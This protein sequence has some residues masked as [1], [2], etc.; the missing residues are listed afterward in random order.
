[1]LDVVGGCGRSGVVDL[2]LAAQERFLGGG[3]DGGAGHAA[4]AQP[5][6]MQCFWKEL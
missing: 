6:G 4:L 2:Q 3:G 1:M 5:Y